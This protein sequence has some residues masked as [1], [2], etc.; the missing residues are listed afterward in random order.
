[1]INNNIEQTKEVILAPGDNKVISFDVI[2]EQEGVYHIEVCGQ[3][4]EF[5]LSA[6]LFTSSRL[7][8]ISFISFIMA[9]IAGIFI[10]LYKPW[11][12]TR[13]QINH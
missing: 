6:P 13:L 7:L 11:L 8:L 10:A 12:I 9:F 3:S 2:K 4:G 5:I 1:M